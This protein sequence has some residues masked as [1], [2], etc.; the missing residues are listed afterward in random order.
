MSKNNILFKLLVVSLIL[1]MTFT[2]CA[3]Q[4]TPAAPAEA[5]QAPAATSSS[6]EPA[7]AEPAATEVN[8]AAT[9]PSATQAVAQASNKPTSADDLKVDVPKPSKKYK[10]ALI[11]GVVKDPFYIS[12]QKAAAD[13]A[14]ALGI[15]IIM[16]GPQEYN[17]VAQTPLIDAMVARGDID[18]LLAV[19]TDAAAMIAPLKRVHDA[20]IPIIT[21]DTYIG[22]NTYG[23]G[24]P[25]DFPIAYIGSDNYEGGMSSCTELAKLIGNKGKVFIQNVIP[26]DSSLDGRQ[27]GCEAVIKQN[28]E[29]SL[30]GVEYNNDDPNQAQSQTAAILTRE[31]DLAG[32]FGTNVYA[33][34]GAGKAVK[35]ADM[36]GKVK[37]VAFDATQISIE[38]LRSGI[39]DVV[40]A[41]K[42]WLMGKLGVDLIRLSSYTRILRA[43]IL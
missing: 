33:A 3:P 15:E 14:K 34:E 27:Q 24:G 18:F 39:N 40:V 26:G 5:Q 41:Q 42:P 22:A 32:I 21:L 13:E 9:L 38:D 36:T 11:V 35:N 7:A 28:P 10:L 4:A 17:P 31:G 2:A 43:L 20:G 6:N 30:A 29:M 1:M 8:T 12:V 25:A 23:A 16:D 37:V 19:P